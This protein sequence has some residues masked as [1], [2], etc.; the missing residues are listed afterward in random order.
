MLT[1]YLSVFVFLYAAVPVSAGQ[2]LGDSLRHSPLKWSRPTQWSGEEGA[3]PL[4][5]SG[6]RA[7]LGAVAVQVA[8]AL[9]I[10]WGSAEGGAQTGAKVQG[11]QNEHSPQVQETCALLLRGESNPAISTTES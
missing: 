7:R 10:L 4:V 5:S 8:S 2:C 6:P 3:A 1:H 9:W 11:V